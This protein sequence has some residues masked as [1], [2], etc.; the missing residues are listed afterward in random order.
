MGMEEST[1]RPDSLQAGLNTF[2]GAH[3]EE[4][5]TGRR[6]PA[7][8]VE[9]DVSWLVEVDVA[10]IDALA[11]L[12]VVAHRCGCSVRLHG[13]GPSLVEMLELVGLREIMRICDCASGS[14]QHDRQ[15][16]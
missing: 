1:H 15:P 9:L 11:R 5:V 3:A 8:V 7:V 13:A 14:V 4:E 6:W 12:Q 10:S 16:G 2:D